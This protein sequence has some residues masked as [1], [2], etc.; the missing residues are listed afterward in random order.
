M[1]LKVKQD[2]HTCHDDHVDMSHTPCDVAFMYEIE[3][4]V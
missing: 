2:V 4:K 1:I 3:S